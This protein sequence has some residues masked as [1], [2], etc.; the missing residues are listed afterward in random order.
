MLKRL[1]VYVALFGLFWLVLAFLSGVL[2]PRARPSGSPVLL[3]LADYTGQLCNVTITGGYLYI[4]TLAATLRKL[5]HSVH[6]LSA[7]EVSDACRRGSLVAQLEG[8]GAKVLD[9]RKS[10]A[11]IDRDFLCFDRLSFPG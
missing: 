11:S 5:G 6:V 8:V 1:P 3:I 2:K 7:Y 4:K 10:G 9:M